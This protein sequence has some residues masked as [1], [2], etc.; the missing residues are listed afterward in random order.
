MTPAPPNQAVLVDPATGQLRSAD[1]SGLQG[2]TGPTGPQV[3]QVQRR[4]GR[5][6][7]Q[8]GYKV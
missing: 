2:P 3:Q 8:W 5:T 7:P 1:L 4:Y 6:I